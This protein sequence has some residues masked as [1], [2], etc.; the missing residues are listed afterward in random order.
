MSRFTLYVKKILKQ[1]IGKRTL[2]SIDYFRLLIPVVARSKAWVCGHL[3]ARMLVG[4][5]PGAEK[6]VS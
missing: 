3:L 4:V 6:S 2:N 5:P 1:T